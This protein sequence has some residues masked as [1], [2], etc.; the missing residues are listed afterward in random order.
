MAL[1]GSW[2]SIGLYP[3][4][5]RIGSKAAV[6]GGFDGVS[7]ISAM[8]CMAIGKARNASYSA[9][10]AVISSFSDLLHP[11]SALSRPAPPIRLKVFGTRRV[12]TVTW[13]PPYHD[14]GARIASFTVVASGAAE[15]AFDSTGG[16]TVRF[17][18]LGKGTHHF[19]VTD[20]N[21]KGTSVAGVVTYKVP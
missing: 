16:L 3:G 13:A 12:T 6:A 21:A 10:R 19:R 7:C 5:I 18:G 1:M 20:T 8:Q 15:G 4:P 11:V 14:G 2:S 9:A 17:V